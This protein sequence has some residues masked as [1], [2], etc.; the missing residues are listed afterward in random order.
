M[1]PKHQ[2]SEES[3]PD[4]IKAYLSAMGKKGGQAGKGKAKSRPSDQMR[5]A[6]Q[7]RWDKRKQGGEA[8]D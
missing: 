2:S 7:K 6:V 1:P 4:P 5:A 8:A 3:P